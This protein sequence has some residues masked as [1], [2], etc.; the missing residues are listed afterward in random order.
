MFEGLFQPMH[1]FIIVAIILILF[2]PSKLPQ[3]GEGI[4]KGIRGFKKAL[5]EDEIDISAK[6]AGKSD[7]KQ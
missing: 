5:S 1:L 2:G 4:G 3:I 7:T 6:P